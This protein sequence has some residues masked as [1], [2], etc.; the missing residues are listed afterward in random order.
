M[1]DRTSARISI[2]GD[3]RSAKQLRQLVAETV[4]DGAGDSYE[5]APDHEIEA[6]IRQAALRVLDGTCDP[7]AAPGFMDIATE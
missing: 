4:N 5:G 6:M 1:G 3:I 2:G 7:N